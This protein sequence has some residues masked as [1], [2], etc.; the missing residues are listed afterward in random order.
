MT[1]LNRETRRQMRKAG[2]AAMSRVIIEGDAVVAAAE[3][4]ADTVDLLMLHVDA[5]IHELVE[6][7]GDVLKHTVITLGAHPDNPGGV[8]IEAK[9]SSLVRPGD[10]EPEGGK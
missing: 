4:G 9:C 2:I 3:K 1:E 5:L 8:T 7:G 6:Q 10:P